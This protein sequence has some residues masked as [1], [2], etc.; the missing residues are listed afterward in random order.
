MENVDTNFISLDFSAIEKMAA[1]KRREIEEEE[2]RE[3]EARERIRRQ[4]LW[5]AAL[6]MIPEVYK[7]TLRENHLDTSGEWGYKC[8]IARSYIR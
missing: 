2:R 3:K 7:E 1:E 5:R 8:G 6:E 4:N